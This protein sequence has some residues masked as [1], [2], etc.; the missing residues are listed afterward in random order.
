MACYLL[1]IIYFI[2]DNE[3]ASH[4]L[5]IPLF[6]KIFPYSYIFISF[7]YFFLKFTSFKAI[8]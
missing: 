5:L 2:L 4:L 7:K 6:T 1:L 8:K 3:T